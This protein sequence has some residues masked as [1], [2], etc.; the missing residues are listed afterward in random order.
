[1]Y[2]DASRARYAY[3]DTPLGQLH[4]AE[5]GEGPPV[6]LLHQTPR[7]LDEYRELQ[8][9][10]AARRRVIAMDMYGFGMS[11]KPPPGPQT[12]EQYASGV[13]ALADALSLERFALVGHHTGMLVAAEVAAA[14]P[15]RI[16]AAV[17]SSG[18]FMTADL[19]AAMTEEMTNGAVDD[20][21]VALAVDVVQRHPDG[22]HLLQLWG[23]R[24]PTYP[25]GRPDLLDRFIRDALAPGVDPA[26]GHLAVARYVME[27]RVSRVTAPLLVLAA[28]DDPHSY[29]FT[30]G[31]AQAFPHSKEVRVV[32]IEG[33]RVPL[34][35]QKTDEVAAAIERFL[36][37]HGV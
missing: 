20:D 15:E 6:V 35:E 21:G 30:S 14:A 10:L 23:K 13:I 36:S 17:L 32:E 18:A 8:P 22:R 24:R 9:L 11:A 19:R 37:A 26:E 34:I 25:E 3:A 16:T 2:S 12:I 28:T 4:Y 33:G 29:P 31:V 1:M 7:S 5:L 27:G